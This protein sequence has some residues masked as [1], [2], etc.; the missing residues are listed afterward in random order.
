MRNS[1]VIEEAG[2]FWLPSTPDSRLPGTLHISERGRITL[3]VI[4]MFGDPVQAFTVNGSLKRIVGLVKSQYV[5]L[6]SCNCKKQN[7]NFG[8]ISRSIIDA[9]VAYL[10]AAYGDEE[11][12]TFSKVRFS[13]EGLDE[14]LF[15]TGLEIEHNFDDLSAT[16]RYKPPRKIP[17]RLPGDI[18]LAFGFSWSLSGGGTEFKEAKISQKASMSLVSSNG[19]PL[20]TFLSIISKLTNFLSFAID[21]TVMLESVT[22]FSTELTREREGAQREQVPIRIYFEST[23]Y[24]EV[25]PK[26][27]WNDM[28]F[29]Y[30]QVKDQLEEILAKWFSNYET[31]EP[32]FNLYFAYKFGAQRYIDGRFLSLA[33]GIETLH[34]RNSTKT[35]MPPAEF[36]NLV[37]ELLK[38]CPSDRKEWLNSR[39]AYSNEISLRQRLVEMIEPFQLIYGTEERVSL[40]IRGVVDTRNYL[41][42]Y[43]ERLSEKAARGGVDLWRLCMKLEVLFQLHFLR[44]M[45][46]S[47]EFIANIVNTVESVKWKLRQ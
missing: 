40:F 41:T 43:D 14:W 31:S 36:S 28:L 19:M 23:S 8:G 29:R 9:R 46:L 38:S 16:I 21:K 34:R 11:T 25:A 30:D 1:T 5:T 26:I 45:G 6:D 42:H 22:G 35:V 18:E 33:Q 17:I 2:Y 44:L 20:E 13:V 37:Q 12:V 3:D 10:G 47:N 32:A 15:I 7:L 24:N 27:S 4:G 39:I